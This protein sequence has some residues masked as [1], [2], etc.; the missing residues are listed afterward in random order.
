MRHNVGNGWTVHGGI[1]SGLTVGDP[2]QSGF[3]DQDM[4]LGYTLGARTDTADYGFGVSAFIGE[5][6]GF[7]IIDG[8]VP[9]TDRFLVY[10]DG[11]YAFTPSLVARGEVMFGKDRDPLGGD[12]PT[13]TDETDVLGY[14]VQLSYMASPASQFVL[15]YE[16]YDPDTGDDVSTNRS[17]STIGFGYI[18]HVNK[19]LKILLA[20]EHP[21][22]KP[23]QKND[24][25]TLRSQF[26]L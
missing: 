12:D 23:S 24:T 11:M 19:N 3:R 18:H 17:I 6:K 8:M 16:N 7:D 15:K 20:Y 14:H 10:I 9:D 21:S 13:F 1:W 26:R 25:W 5:R 2:Q 4:R 22:E